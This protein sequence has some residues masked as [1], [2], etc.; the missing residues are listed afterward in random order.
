MRTLHLGLTGD[1]VRA[2]EHY[3][4]GRYPDSGLVVDDVFDQVTK[5]LTERFQGDVGFLGSDVDGVVGPMTLGRAMTNG[6]NPLEDDRPDDDG[7]NWPPPPDEGPLTGDARAQLFGAFAYRPAPTP[8]N[9]EAI[10]ITD[11]WA[12]SNI[13]TVDVPQ[14][15][16]VMGAG[17][18]KISVHRLIA[19]QVLKTFADWEAAGLKDRILSWGGSW[20]PRFIRGSRTY[21]S[22][23]AWGTAF[24]INVPWNMLGSQ[25]ALKGQRGCTRELVK[26]AYDNGL[27]WGGWFKGRPDGMHFEARKV[28]S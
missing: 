18:G 19:P 20:A 21:L 25:P 22:N 9:P 23:H 3:L 8:Q 28:I 15:H 26:I 10:V 4:L 16:G 13:I 6:F 14:L 24:D 1:D 12:A 11:N 2:W 7:P 17:S 5:D 27:Y